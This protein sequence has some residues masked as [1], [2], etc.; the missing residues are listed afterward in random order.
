MKTFQIIQTS[1]P[2]YAKDVFKKRGGL[3]E[4]RILELLNQG[5]W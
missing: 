4:G 3:L 5:H 2:T 1:R